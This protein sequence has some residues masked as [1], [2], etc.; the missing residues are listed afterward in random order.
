MTRIGPRG[1]AE[2]SLYEP[3]SAVAIETLLVRV[4]PDDAGRYRVH[5]L[6]LYA[7]SDP[8]TAERIRAVRVAAVEQL[9]NLPEERALL[10]KKFD[11]PLPGP[12]LAEFIIDFVRGFEV[13]QHPPRKAVR[14]QKPSAKL[15]APG[16]R[17]YPDD[18]YDRV[19]DV[20]RD[21]FR[22][23][24]RRPVVDVA[25]EAGVPRSTAARWVK[26]ARRRGLLGPAP[27]PGK[28]GE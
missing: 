7:K 25:N 1:W 18:F 10:E 13:P 15:S 19:A 26:E 21:S 28:K 4:R 14:G 5:E 23:N 3:G 24:S 9:L 6:H 8:L 11:D 22:G 20:Y 17:G 16:Q 27:A 12:H 2:V